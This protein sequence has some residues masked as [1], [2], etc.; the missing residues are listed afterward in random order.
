MTA[1]AFSQMLN[2]RPDIAADN[3][4][5]VAPKPTSLFHSEITV[6]DGIKFRSKGEAGRYTVLKRYTEE[7][8]ISDLN[9]QPLFVLQEKTVIGGER[10]GR[11]TYKADF[12]YL[13]SGVL[14]VEDW[15]RKSRDG[16]LFLPPEFQRTY[17]MFRV[18]YP[19]VHFWLNGEVSAL[20][21]G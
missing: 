7:G 15:K 6:V 14:W 17:K 16:T 10:L 8:L 20:P 3:P 13:Y 12:S 21:A 19:E 11:I 9:L 2:A 18:R 1:K 5:L 4:G